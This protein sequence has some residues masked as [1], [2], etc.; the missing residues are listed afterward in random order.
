MTF[1]QQ[2]TE[3]IAAMTVFFIILRYQGKPKSIFVM[4]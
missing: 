3:I 4:A 1:A 2:G